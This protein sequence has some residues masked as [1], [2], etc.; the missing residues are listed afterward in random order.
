MSRESLIVNRHFGDINPRVT[1]KERCAPSHS[2]GPAVRR[3]Y[4][5]HFVVSGKGMFRYE[6]REYALGA[7]DIFVAAPEKEMF[8]QADKADPW[9]YIWVGFSGGLDIE[10]VLDAPVLHAPECGEIF[11]DF[12]KTAD[13]GEGAELYLCAKIFELLAR[14]KAHKNS[15]EQN[16]YRYVQLAKNYIETQYD[17]DL[18][19]EGIADRLG[20]ER[21]YFSKLFKA[22]IGISPQQYLV[23][24]RLQRAAEL[25]RLH[26]YTPAQAAGCVGYTDLFNFSKMFKKFYGLAPRFYYD[27]FR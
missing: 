11:A 4:L 9:S 14:L 26:H 15:V 16:A 7:G 13:Y 10:S 18:S 25:M 24:Y 21:S 27:K 1:G 5:M 20:L 19:V 6:G 23:R 17:R 2:Y 22:Q 8:Y 3:Y 12:T